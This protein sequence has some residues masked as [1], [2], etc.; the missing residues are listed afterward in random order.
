MNAPC[1]LASDAALQAYLRTLTRTYVVG[2]WHITPDGTE[3]CHARHVLVPYVGTPEGLAR[4]HAVGRAAALV[5]AERHHWCGATA[6]SLHT[7]RVEL[8]F[9]ADRGPW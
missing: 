6:A 1:P 2:L 3:C 5:E 8:E 4:K 9:T 7:Y